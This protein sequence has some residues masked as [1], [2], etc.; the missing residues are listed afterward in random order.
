MTGLVIHQQFYCETC[1]YRG[2]VY[3]EREPEENPLEIAEINR[4]R[5]EFAE[6]L[7][8]GLG[9]SYTQ[10]ELATMAIKEKW[11]ENQQNNHSTLRSWC[12]FCADVDNQCAWCKCPPEICAK[13]ATEGLIGELNRHFEPQ[14]ELCNVNPTIYQ[15]IVNK[16]RKIASNNQ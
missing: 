11:T 1:G 10:K 6:D 3:A 5:K 16:F 12:P 4:L 7:E 14:T 9:Q 8:P 13:H 15:Q 2:Y